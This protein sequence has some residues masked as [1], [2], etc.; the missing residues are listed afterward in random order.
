[1]KPDAS[2][3][4]QMQLALMGIV[5]VTGLFYLWRSLCRIE[6][7]VTR[8]TS[9]V[10]NQDSQTHKFGSV[11][12]GASGNVE[13]FRSVPLNFA[14]ADSAAEELMKQVFGDTEEVV[15][16]HSS[17][18]HQQTTSGSGQVVIEDATPI[19]EPEREREREA[20]PEPSE[21]DTDVSNPLSKSKLNKMTPEQLKELATQRGLS[22][23]GNKR[24]LIDRLLGL[25]KD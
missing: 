10:S 4:L 2:L 5:L 15:L 21:A 17:N 22:T 7:K 3:L 23:E 25:T 16:I 1:M 20:D 9:L 19:A 14:D 18:L 11:S 6:D 24:S 13:D 12:G 8:L